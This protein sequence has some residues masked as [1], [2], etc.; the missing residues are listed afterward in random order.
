[1]RKSIFLHSGSRK[2][3]GFMRQRMAMSFLLAVVCSLCLSGCGLVKGMR[4]D[5]VTVLDEIWEEEVSEFL[6]QNEG[7]PIPFYAS[8]EEAVDSLAM[9]NRV[10][11]YGNDGWGGMPEAYRFAR[12]MELG[13]SSEQ[14]DSLARHHA[15]PA[16]RAVAGRI[17]I[18]A[19]SPLARSLVMSGL[20]DTGHFELQCFDVIYGDNVA[21]Y[22]LEYAFR[23]H[24]L[25]EADSLRLI[26]TL[27]FSPNKGHIGLR[28]KVLQSLGPQPQYYE[29][30]R[31]ILVEEQDPAA[32]PWLAQYRR[33]EDTAL[34]LEALRCYSADDSRRTD[35]ECRVYN[36]MMA[37][38]NGGLLAV[39]EWPHLVFQP[40]LDSIRDDLAAGL[41]DWD[42][43][44]CLFSAAMAYRSEWALQFIKETFDM[45]KHHEGNEPD[46]DLYDGVGMW[47]HWWGECFHRAYKRNPDEYFAKIEKKYGFRSEFESMYE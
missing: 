23:A 47:T 4:G 9:G 10:S 44:R 17:L 38:R 21:N 41:M 2:P 18:D 34:V 6:L 33:I 32:L 31:R 30:F 14:L 35:E 12:Q 16:V 36:M 11:E 46:K 8:L 20:S 1:M 25:V 19:K 43:T 7:R 40:L 39:A 28:N 15:S 42:G 22:W 3:K 45:V 26:D 13:F 29:V 27:I 24:I 5:D 37:R